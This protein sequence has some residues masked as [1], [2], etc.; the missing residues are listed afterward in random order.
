[1]QEPVQSAAFSLDGSILIIGCTTGHWF[2]M[3]AET[4]E[5]YSM[6][7]D[8]TEPIQVLAT[9]FVSSLSFVYNDSFFFFL[10]FLSPQHKPLLPSLYYTSY[11]INTSF[12]ACLLLIQKMSFF[13]IVCLD[14]FLYSSLLDPPP[15][16][17]AD[18]QIL[19]AHHIKLYCLAETWT[20]LQAGETVSLGDIILVNSAIAVL[21]CGKK[22]FC[23][24]TSGPC[25]SY[26]TTF[27]FQSST[28]QIWQFTFAHSGQS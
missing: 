1:V 17:P 9:L 19:I 12:R 27:F 18:S 5:V 13:S 23:G 6:H 8:G 15:V 14:I 2:V 11:C 21:Q 10:I 25:S 28:P 7:T 26:F 3:D 22:S 4:R 16:F 20:K 24:V